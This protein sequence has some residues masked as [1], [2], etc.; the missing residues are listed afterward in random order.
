M[1]LVELAAYKAREVKA[2]LSELMEMAERGDLQ[3]LV[4]VCKLG[5][6]DHRAG[7]A[8]D[9]KRHPEQALPAIYMLKDYLAQTGRARLVE[10]G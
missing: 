5:V 8:G 4:F 10:S 6:D 9:Y 1:Q 2:V 7:R 3:G